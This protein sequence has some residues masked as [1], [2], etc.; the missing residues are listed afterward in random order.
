MNDKKTEKKILRLKHVQKK[1]LVSIYKNYTGKYSLNI[2]DG[3]I[4]SIKKEET[5]NLDD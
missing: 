2:K 3:W 5:E 4:K 1:L